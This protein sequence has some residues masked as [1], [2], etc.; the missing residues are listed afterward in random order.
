VALTVSNLAEQAGLTADTVRYYDR[1]GLLPQPAR[2]DAGYRLFEEGTA[3]RLRFIKGAQRVGL[4]LRE[5]SELLRAMD[6]GECPCPET[7]ALLRQRM[8]EID[9]EV[10][11]L[12]EV[13]A[14]LARLV[15]NAPGCR[16]PGELWCEREFVERG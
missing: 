1:L 14:E 9:A 4:R 11:R 2:S 10:A 5:I 3:R 12:A 16:V 15:D 6:E 7:E 8:A 13:R